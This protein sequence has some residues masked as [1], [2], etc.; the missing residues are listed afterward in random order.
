MVKVEIINGKERQFVVDTMGNS[1]PENIYVI[2][3]GERITLNISEKQIKKIM[4]ELPKG[5]QINIIKG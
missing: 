1:K 3:L 2:G 5:A 4:N